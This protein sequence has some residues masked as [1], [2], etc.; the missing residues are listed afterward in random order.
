M[1][2]TMDKEHRGLKIPLA[3]LWKGILLYSMLGMLAVLIVSASFLQMK[4]GRLLNAARL[5]SAVQVDYLS[6]L[7]ESY[8]QAVRSDLSFLPELNELIRYKSLPNEQ[9]RRDI[10]S[11]FHEF[12]MSKDVY[13]QIRYL[14]SEGLERI[15]VNNLES[16]E[17]RIVPSE[18]L[19]D[20][21][22]RYYFREALSLKRGEVYV[23]PLDLNKEHG[24]IETP[25]KP[26]IRFSTPVWGE[27]GAIK[28]VLILNYL[29]TTFLKE[30][31]ISTRSHPGRFGLLNDQGFWLYHE[32]SEREWGF[33]FPGNAEAASL[34]E[35]APD[36][37]DAVSRDEEGQFL[38]EQKL[39]TVK[40]ISPM[41]TAFSIR[42]RPHWILVNE[43][44]FDDIGAAPRQ[45]WLPLFIILAVSAAFVLPPA[46]FLALNQEQKKRYQE[47]LAHSA[48][49]DPLTGLPNRSLLKARAS[50]L[51]SE[52]RRYHFS[53]A[54]M[55]VDL[56]GF[57]AVN[58]TYGHDD[59]DLVL[60]ETAGRLKMSVRESDTVSRTGGDEFVILLHRINRKE[61]A[62][63]VAGN[64]LDALGKPFSV[65]GGELSIGASIGIALSDKE[66]HYSLDE[67][68]I[69]AD[70]AM[71]QV[72]RNGKNN[73]AYINL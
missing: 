58:D 2:S 39:Y 18:E 47:A 48:G 56:D 32:N 57:K 46:W 15:R 16:G 41:N 50:L 5:R 71:Y 13:D 61:D 27:N 24:R 1:G 33:M 35:R 64:I 8:F 69:Q 21:G 6:E 10:E 12:C 52:A 49:H 54:L 66:N 29:A 45:F 72:K 11:E 65:N 26:M 30:L 37:W 60:K 20:K 44:R 23:S 55:F 17:C 31:E 43:L 9:D 68:L 67:L 59:G 38:Y 63:V 14:D 19:Q 25:L 4:R 51:E 28:G 3:D 7:I 53:Y 73:Y 62:A 22:G 40:A 36:L 70:N 42:G 34:E